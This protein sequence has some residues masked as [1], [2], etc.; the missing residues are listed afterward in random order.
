M[1]NAAIIFACMQVARCKV[2]EAIENGTLEPGY[3]SGVSRIRRGV[4]RVITIVHACSIIIFRI[5]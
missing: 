2:D 4:S 5:S 1:I 3:M